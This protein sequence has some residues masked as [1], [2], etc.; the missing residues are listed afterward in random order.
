MKKILITV[1][2]AVLL[3]QYAFAQFFVGGGLSFAFQRTE[4]VGQ[5]G[6]TELFSTSFIPL[7]GYRFGIADVGFFYE[8]LLFEY[9]YQP[10]SGSI[11]RSLRIRSV[12][13]GIFCELQLFSRGNL[14]IS[15]RG[16]LLRTALTGLD[17]NEELRIDIDPIIEFTIFDR[18][19][20]F[21]NIGLVQFRPVALDR[22]ASSF[23]LSLL[24]DLT[25][26]VRFLFE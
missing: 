9:L 1:L 16:S 17:H 20:F 23:T 25:L 19:S 21:T 12:S 14:S 8:H 4:A 26:G 10:A 6:T 13:I 3:S 7:L 22:R 5:S 15:G 2:L 24:S 11:P 18:L